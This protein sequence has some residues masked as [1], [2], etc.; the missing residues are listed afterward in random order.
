MPLQLAKWEFVD[1]N[2]IAPLRD[3]LDD[4]T[5]ECMRQNRL[6]AVAEER[7]ERAN[8]AT[9]DANQRAD[10]AKRRLEEDVAA[11]KTIQKRL[12]AL[13]KMKAEAERQTEHFK[14]ETAKLEAQ[15]RQA[16]NSRG[17]CVGQIEAYAASE[18]ANVHISARLV[19]EKEA[20]D[21]NTVS[22]RE[23]IDCKSGLLEAV[24][25]YQKEMRAAEGEEPT[26]TDGAVASLKDAGRSNPLGFTKNAPRAGSSRTSF[27]SPAC[28]R[29]S[30]SARSTPVLCERQLLRELAASRFSTSSRCSD[31]IN[32]R[33][34]WPWF[35][36]SVLRCWLRS[37]RIGPCWSSRRLFPEDFRVG[38][39][40]AGCR[41][42]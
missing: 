5:E 13:Q 17:D 27:M 39:G 42:R 10:A 9:A 38:S 24:H 7:K 35:V 36:L 40:P 31:S 6:R 28:R 21:K 30:R 15:I 20:I 41:C 11:E 32:A 4:L 22:I 14:K 26:V 8:R 33:W 1:E 3:E 34:P 19:A 18:R 37:S 23:K 12:T 2:F 16:E 29:S 25:I